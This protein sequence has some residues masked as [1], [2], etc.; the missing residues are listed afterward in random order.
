M[1]RG[2][3]YEAPRVAARPGETAPRPI[4]LMTSGAGSNLKP[5]K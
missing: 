5:L 4:G 3:L 1:A 2:I